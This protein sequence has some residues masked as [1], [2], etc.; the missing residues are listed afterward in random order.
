MEETYYIFCER[1]SWILLN[2]ECN[3]VCCRG[4]I[5]Y[6]YFGASLVFIHEDGSETMSSGKV[7]SK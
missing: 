5:I 6:V 2:V 7:N 3:G 4:R 1:T